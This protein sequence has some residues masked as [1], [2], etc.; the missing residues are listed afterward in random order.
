MTGD[1]RWWLHPDHESK[2]CR[3][4]TQDGKRCKGLEVGDGR[5]KRHPPGSVSGPRTTRHRSA[6][7]AEPKQR[8]VALPLERGMKFGAME[9]VKPTSTGAYVCMCRCGGIEMRSRSAILKAKAGG[10]A[11]ACK[12][13]VKVNQHKALSGLAVSVFKGNNA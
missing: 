6:P 12:K 10:R 8:A 4:L 7:P 9:V 5:C 13:C 1:A 2:R 3:E 11:S